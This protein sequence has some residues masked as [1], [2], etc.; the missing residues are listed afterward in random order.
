M[1]FNP[2]G[3]RVLALRTQLPPAETVEVQV[4]D[5]LPG[6]V[7]RVAGKAVAGRFH[8]HLA[9]D[10]GGYSDQPTEGELVSRFGFSCR[11]Q[12]LLRHDQEVDRRDPHGVVLW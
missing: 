10:S 7:A 12:V 2:R 4:E 5:R 3:R 11:R 6:I 1:F 9:G 8:S